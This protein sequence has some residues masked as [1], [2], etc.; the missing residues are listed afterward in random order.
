MCSAQ[1]LQKRCL[2]FGSCARVSDDRLMS[3]CTFIALNMSCV[4]ADLTSGDVLPH[5]RSFSAE[6]PMGHQK[7][8]HQQGCPSPGSMA[9]L[10]HLTGWLL[11]KAGQEDG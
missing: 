7:A 1:V 11:K 8:D 6:R 2:H 9:A 3:P 10:A 4:V 5:T